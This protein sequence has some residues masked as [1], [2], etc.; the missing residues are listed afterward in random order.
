MGSCEPMRDSIC[1]LTD[2][3]AVTASSKGTALTSGAGTN[4]KGAYVEFSSS[5]ARDADYLIINSDTFAGTGFSALDIAVGANGSEQPILNNLSIGGIVQTEGRS[6]FIPFSIPATT[7]LSAR[8][9]S[10]AAA[11]AGNNIDI[12]FGS[13]SAGFKPFRVCDTYGWTAASTRGTSLDPG[14]TANTKG[15]YSQIVA[16]TTR[17]HN[18]LSWMLDNQGDTTL[19]NASLLMDIAIGGAGSEQVIIPNIIC[20]MNTVGGINPVSSSIIPVQIPSGTRLAA[21]VQSSVNTA[22]AR[23]IGITLYGLS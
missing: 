3:G 5:L 1:A 14:G 21:R 4:G 17:D 23:A 2:L 8:I 6:L 16:A 12:L 18:G 7:R 15:A 11:D 19:S 9:Q 10:S 20:R 22:A 13:G